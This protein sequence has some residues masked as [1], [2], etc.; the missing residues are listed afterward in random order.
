MMFLG[1]AGAVALIARHLLPVEEVVPAVSRR[2]APVAAAQ[3]V[4]DSPPP[5]LELP[6]RLERRAPEPDSSARDVFEAKSWAPPPPPAAAAPPAPVVAPPLPFRFIGWIDDGERLRP[7]LSRDD[8]VFEVAEGD[9]LDPGYRVE[10]IEPTR[11][12]FLYVPMSQTQTLSLGGGST[13]AAAPAT[14]REPG[15][16]ASATPADVPSEVAPPASAAGISPDQLDRASV[17]I[18]IRQQQ[19]RD[20]ARERATRR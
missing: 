4:P 19:M 17:A 14:V 12:T 5:S 9:A 10:R 6:D 8:E 15:A 7:F 20:R 3:A 11:I 2:G 18:R 13:Q 16:S 1:L